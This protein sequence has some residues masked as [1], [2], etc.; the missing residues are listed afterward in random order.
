METKRLPPQVVRAL[1][2]T[3]TKDGDER[4]RQT[5]TDGDRRRQTETDAR[6]LAL[7]TRT[8]AG[9]ENKDQSRSP[10]ISEHS[11]VLSD[12]EILSVSAHVTAPIRRPRMGYLQLENQIGSSDYYRHLFTSESIAALISFNAQFTDSSLPLSS[13]SSSSSPPPPP[14]PPHPMFFSFNPSSL[15]P[16]ALLHPSSRH[17]L[18]PFN[19]YVFFTTSP[20]LFP[21]SLPPWCLGESRG[22]SSCLM[23]E[24][25]PGSLS[26]ERLAGLRVLNTYCSPPPSPPSGELSA[27][28]AGVGW[29]GGEP[30]G[31][32]L[33]PAVGTFIAD[34]L[35]D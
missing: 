9:R 35:C 33:I 18:L 11:P 30:L 1:L 3:E 20:P 19:F 12:P 31:A 14:P 5:E 4:R 23:N 22:N 27:G 34:Y 16:H 17:C 6:P 8:T 15:C 28:W 25:L 2:M 7:E 13:P 29:G 26:G 24:L 32:M 21:S 10:N